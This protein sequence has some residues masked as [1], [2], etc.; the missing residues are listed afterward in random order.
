MVT[1]FFDPGN[2]GFG[3]LP[4]TDPKTGTCTGWWLE[5]G[6]PE[7][8]DLAGELGLYQEYWAGHGTLDGFR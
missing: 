8:D 2:R 7:H 5:T 1:A 4:V 6:D 3:L